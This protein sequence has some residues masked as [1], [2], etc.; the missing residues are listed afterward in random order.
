LDSLRFSFKA[1]NIAFSIG[2]DNVWQAL[3]NVEQHVPE[4][5]YRKRY[6]NAF[7]LSGSTRIK[8]T[9]NPKEDAHELKRKN[10]N[11]EMMQK[12][13]PGSSTG[14]KI[15]NVVFQDGEILQGVGDILTS[16]TSSGGWK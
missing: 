16:I 11:V 12:R 3:K 4:S 8:R 6:K 13:T 5:I 2:D 14:M 1:A 10:Y 9:S 7:F 15:N